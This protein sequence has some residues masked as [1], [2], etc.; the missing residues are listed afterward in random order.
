MKASQIISNA[1][2]NMSPESAYGFQYGIGLDRIIGTMV[3]CIASCIDMHHAKYGS[4]LEYN[5][6]I[7]PII[8]QQ[9]DGVKQLLKLDSVRQLIGGV[10]CDKVS[11][12]LDDLSA[13]SKLHFN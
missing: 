13:L 8:E 4:H 2:K 1:I 11:S 5:E 6:S 3:C 9:I 12:L 7:Y 10:D